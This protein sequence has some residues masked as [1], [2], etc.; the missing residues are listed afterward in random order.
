MKVIVLSTVRRHRLR[1]WRN[2]VKFLGVDK[3]SG[4]TVIYEIT[5]TYWRLPK[6]WLPES[7]DDHLMKIRPNT[8]D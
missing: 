5:I 3:V 1:K 6:V 4:V 7:L 8:W 2:A